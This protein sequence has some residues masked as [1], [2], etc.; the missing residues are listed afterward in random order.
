MAKQRLPKA[1]R[2]LQIAATALELLA[3]AGPSGL[4]LVDLGARIGVTDAS[5]LRHF[6]DKSAVI[7]AAIAHFGTLLNEDIVSD[8]EDPLRRLAA[9]FARRLAKVQQH[10][11][12]IR[13]AHSDRLRDMASADGAAQLDKHLAQSVQFVRQCIEQAQAEGC[14]S[15]AVPAQMWVWII[16]G[17]MRGASGTLPR[18]LGGSEPQQTSP[19]RAWELLEQLLVKR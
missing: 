13:L 7:D 5:I 11:E 3:E 12:I 14:V 17:V 8:V 18:P 16:V 6:S 19:E 2:R 9:F 10:P 4:T 15:D 1:Q